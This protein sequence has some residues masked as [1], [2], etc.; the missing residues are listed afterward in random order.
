MRKHNVPKKE[1]LV[2][3]E[4]YKRLWIKR[5]EDVKPPPPLG[6]PIEELGEPLNGFQC[7]GENDCRSLT[8]SR[9][10]LRKH[11]N[12]V[13]K[14]AW[15]KE[16]TEGLFS[17]VKVQTFFNTG[18]LRRY[19]TVRASEQPEDQDADQD[20][21]EG[22][23]N[24]WKAT[25]QAQELE[26]QVMDAKA[27]KT[28]RTG[29]FNRTRWLEHLAERNRVHLAHAIRL[30]G[31]DE[32]K[33]KQAA[34]AVEKL[35]EQSVAGLSSLPRET[36]R[37]LRS[38]QA[39][40]ID[41]RPMARLQNPESQARY[42][43]YIVMFVCYFLRVIADEEARDHACSSSGRNSDNH[44]D[45]DSDNSDDDRSSG[46]EYSTNGSYQKETPDFMKDARELF[47][48]QGRQREL[49]MALWLTL[50]GRDEGAHVDA[51]LAVLAAFIFEPIVH[52]VFDSGL[53]HFL[54]VLG[55]DAEMD[56]L[57]TAKNY[58]YMLAGVV[59]CVRV[60]G[61]EALLPAGERDEQGVEERERFLEKRRQFLAD[62]SYSPMSEMISL[63]AYG[64]FVALNAGNSGSVYWSKDKKIFYLHGKPIV[65]CQFQ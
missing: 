45:A 36:R 22:L 14:L 12:R 11:C 50:D 58:S 48:W 34:N 16:E 64:K 40:E 26:A 21:V 7:H 37:W 62:G 61:V 19:F 9:D 55:I 24:G 23:I 60:I 65:L 53:V 28:D 5:P 46:G 44:D 47:P 20:E 18:G 2:I 6:P 43:G 1:R 54:A 30:P 59:Y 27:A 25:Q 39:T 52:T 17:Q 51:L 3:V 41:Q 10:E 15:R 56:R 31:R 63:L 13:H 38:A 29:W 32:P 49:A 33:L 57:R 4:H 35:V 42:A 8:I